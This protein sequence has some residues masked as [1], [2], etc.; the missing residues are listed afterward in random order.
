MYV[1]VFHHIYTIRTLPPLYSMYNFNHERWLIIAG[2]NRA[3]REII[4]DCFK[5]AMQRR[6]FGKR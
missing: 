1:M 6:V 5:W 4:T 3:S 2:V